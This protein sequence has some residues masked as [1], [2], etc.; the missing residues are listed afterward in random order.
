MHIL[1]LSHY[2]PPEVNAPASRTSEHCRQWVAD[3]EDVTVITCVPNHPQ[4]KIFPGYRNRFF[5]RSSWEGV[6][7]LR[8]LTYITP[9]EGFLKR[10]ANY[11]FY[12]IAATVAALFARRADVVVTTSPQF[13]NGLAGYLVSIV[14]RAPWVLEIR[15][16]WPESI[17]ELGAI[18]SPR[19]IALLHAMARFAYRKADHIVVVTDAF[20]HNLLMLGIPSEKITV[21]KNGAD[22]SMFKSTAR[23]EGFLAAN[24]LRDRFVASYVGTHGL[25]HG[26][27][28]VLEAAKLLLDRHD[29][30]FLLVGDGAD[31]RRL[32]AK[33]DEMGLKNV[34]MLELQSRDRMPAIWSATDASLIV[35]RDKPVFRTVIPSKMFEAMAMKK[36]IILGVA[37]ESRQMVESADAGLCIPPEDHRALADA[38]RTLADNATLVT[39]LGE[40]GYRYV[41]QNYDRTLLARSFNALLSTIATA[42]RPAPSNAGARRDGEQYEAPRN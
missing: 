30:A 4:G 16:L 1:F 18:K 38:V 26:L 25:A 31:R 11:V 5:Q 19:I 34:V 32:L 39:R 23:D 40:N 20:R 6:R 7:V 13:F 8:V 37:G 22:L 17:L 33:R 28:V 36:P 12:M 35:L 14:H 24:G 27:E 15:D 9:N 10:T 21:I 41:S 3:G 2:F 42:H 29:I